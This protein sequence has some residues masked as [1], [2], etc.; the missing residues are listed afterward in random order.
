MAEV[1]QQQIM[2]AL[3]GV[4]DPDRKADIVSLGMVSGLAVKDGHVAFAIEVDP[5]RGPRLEPLRKAAEL[6]VS[7]LPGVR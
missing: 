7:G 2:G 3:K 4:L 5:E 1:T 6:A